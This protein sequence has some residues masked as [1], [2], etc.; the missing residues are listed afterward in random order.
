VQVYFGKR[1]GWGCR[2]FYSSGGI[3]PLDDTGHQNVVGRIAVRSP[4][5]AGAPLHR[6]PFEAGPYR[7]SDS[8]GRKGLLEADPEAVSTSSLLGQEA[9]EERNEVVHGAVEAC[10]RSAGGSDRIV[11]ANERASR[12]YPELNQRV[13]LENRSDE[14]PDWAE[15]VKWSH[16]RVFRGKSAA[17]RPN[18]KVRSLLH[19]HA[20]G[21]LVQV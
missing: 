6:P 4:K 12:K 17:Y 19:P 9:L 2:Q 11:G 21:T 18:R 20:D 13:G 5:R 8:P 1:P 14:K 10:L 3:S 7:S 16:P 15:R